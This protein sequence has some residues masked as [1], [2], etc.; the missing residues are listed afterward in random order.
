MVLHDAMRIRKS[1]QENFHTFDDTL[2][3][4][5]P[6]HTRQIY[7]NDDITNWFYYIISFL[8]VLM[9]CVRFLFGVKKRENQNNRCFRYG[10]WNE[11]E[12]IWGPM[13]CWL[14]RCSWCR[15]LLLFLQHATTFTIH[16]GFFFHFHISHLYTPINAYIIIEPHAFSCSQCSCLQK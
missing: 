12:W 5:K 10:L 14:N 15:L 8:S 11:W 2:R 4:C 7:D 6:K 9:W 16:R 13:S 3:K 1:V